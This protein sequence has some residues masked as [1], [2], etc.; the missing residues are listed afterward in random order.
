M[1]YGRIRCVTGITC[2]AGGRHSVGRERHDGTDPAGT[3]GWQLGCEEGRGAEDQRHADERG[4][5]EGVDLEHQPAQEA[6][7]R[8]RRGQPER[9]A[10]G[11][12]LETAR[13]G[14]PYDA[15]SVR[16][17]AFRMPVSRIHW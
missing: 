14:Q 1:P 16:A 15:R 3:A 13:D 11:H 9:S 12:P 4:G 5:A 2:R 6:G 10:E 8:P 7:L 17:S